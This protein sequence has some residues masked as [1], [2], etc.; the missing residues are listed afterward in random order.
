MNELK[1]RS[2]LICED[3]RQ[4]I[5]GRV[6][7][8]GVL[9]AK[10]FVTRFPFKFL[11]LCLFIEWEEVVGKWDVGINIVKPSGLPLLPKPL[12]ASIEGQPGLT[13]RSMIVLE[14]FEFP[15]AGAYK[16]EFTANGKA[17]GSEHFTLEKF[18]PAPQVTN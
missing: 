11:K 2:V 4:E 7:L 12:A 10:L 15:E 16:F 18:E 5:N 6:S 13:A 3:I 8:M 9:A 17:I 1:Y 14:N